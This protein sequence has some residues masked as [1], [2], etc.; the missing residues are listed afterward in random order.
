MADWTAF[1]VATVVLTLLLLFLTYRSQQLLEEVTVVD[2][3]ETLTQRTEVG[4]AEPTHFD[5]PGAVER[6]FEAE[7]S[8]CV[9]DEHEAVAD[10]HEAVADEHEA[11]AGEPE[12]QPA[13]APPGEFLTT[14]LLLV[15]VL[16]SQ[17]AFL[18]ALAGLAWWTDVPASAFGLTLATLD[19]GT[20][21]V[22][23]AAGVVLYA[24]N[25]TAA[26]LGEQFGFSA[27]EALRSAMAPTDRA[28]WALLLLAVL[29]TI[30]IFEE[31]L[32][33]GALVGVLAVG[34]GID[35][36]LLVVASSAVFGLG[37]G[38][39]GRL[40]ILVTAGIGVV[41]GAVFVLT[42]NL[43]VVILAH[44]VINALE[45]VIQEGIR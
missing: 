10:E 24:G 4:G 36:W 42:G 1:A 43:F 27:P 32:F 41:L 23:L 8:G 17:G 33:R 15:N 9:A 28:E 20:V 14:R 45:F 6:E 25:E 44:Y 3:R 12:D 30:A 39:Q 13:G 22:G 26:R 18:A 31:L 34:F 29:P 21:A 11:I 38:A 35:P 7:E 37:H 40:G 2:D 19:A 16:F 5:E